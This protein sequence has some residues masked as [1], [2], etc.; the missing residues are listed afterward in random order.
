MDYRN[1]KIYEM[2]NIINDKVFIGSTINKLPKRFDFHRCQ[3][4]DGNRSRLCH[5]MR[6]LGS[7]NF[8]IKLIENY[9]CKNRNELSERETWHINQR[10]PALNAQ[11]YFL[12]PPVPEDPPQISNIMEDT[13]NTLN[14]IK[15]NELIAKV[16]KLEQQLS[17]LQQVE[18]MPTTVVDAEARPVRDLF[19]C[20]RGKIPGECIKYMMRIAN[21]ILIKG[22]HYKE[23]P[24]DA[25]NAD[26]LMHLRRWTATK[27]QQNRSYIKERH[28]KVDKERNDLFEALLKKK[29]ERYSL[30]P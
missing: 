4:R 11:T 15:I 10:K 2:T 6:T 24:K 5:E 28:G 18:D 12:T 9:P 14:D 8:R 20:L 7:D 17:E 19:A 22:K 13:S 29:L 26:E 3:A 27:V 30:R 23:H 1:G 21:D 16:A 25:D